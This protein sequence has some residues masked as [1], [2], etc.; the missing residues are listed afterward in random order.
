MMYYITVMH[1]LSPSTAAIVQIHIYK[2]QTP[3]PNQKYLFS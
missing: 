1:D 2:E 3:W